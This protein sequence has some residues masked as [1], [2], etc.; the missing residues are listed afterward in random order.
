MSVEFENGL[1]RIIRTVDPYG[2]RVEGAVDHSTV[3]VF[4]ASLDRIVKATRQDVHADLGGVRFIDVA[5]VRALVSV[6]SRLED[7]RLLVLDPVPRHVRHLLHLVGWDAVPGLR[8]PR[9]HDGE[10]HGG[11]AASDD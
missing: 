10:G 1:L 4:G 3:A 7:G 8:L 2:L 9:P 6:A 11:R 5:G